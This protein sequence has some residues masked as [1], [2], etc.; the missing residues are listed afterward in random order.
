MDKFILRTENLTKCYGEKRALDNVSITIERGRVYG[1]VG[2]NGAGKTTLM[3]VLTGLSHPSEG[4]I[5]LFGCSDKKGIVEQR[6][7]I[8]SMIETPA[9]YSYMSALENVDAVRISQGI[10]DR[11]ISNKILS[12]VKLSDTGNKKI[13][14]FS[15]GMKQRLGIALTLLNS[16]EFI[17]LDEPT[18]GLDPVSIIETRNMLQELV[19]DRLV[20]VMISSHALEQLYHI[21]TDYIFIHEG[22]I[23]QTIT[24]EKL[25]ARCKKHIAIQPVNPEF[26]VTIIEG[27]LKTRNYKVMPDNTINLYDYVDD[28][29]NVVTAFVRNDV[30]IRNITVR[31]DDLE[32]YFVNLIGGS[33]HD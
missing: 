28:M 4:K 24:K 31:G 10:P 1:L 5:E 13:R 18:N 26:A 22:K 30:A 8:G 7:K 16:P 12:K 9:F 21:A 19:T 11:S 29:Q 27:K 14:D 33:L 2:Q 25:D 20:T 23:I 15:L 3:R 6:K 32:N 17:M